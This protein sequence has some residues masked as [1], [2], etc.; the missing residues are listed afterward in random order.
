MD[1]YIIWNH[2]YMEQ[3]HTSLTLHCQHIVPLPLQCTVYCYII[4]LDM[5]DCCIFIQCNV[6]CYMSN[7]HQV[8][9]CILLCLPRQHTD[10]VHA[11][12]TLYVIHHE[13]RDPHAAVNNETTRIQIVRRQAYDGLL[14][15]WILLL[16]LVFF[17]WVVLFSGGYDDVDVVADCVTVPE[18]EAPM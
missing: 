10:I 11:P 7:C 5:V 13:R 14:L 16:F 18:T 2:T 12:H 4:R 9:C 3:T 1:M 15:V 6:Y 8:D 17:R